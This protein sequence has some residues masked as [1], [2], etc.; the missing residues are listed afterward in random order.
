MKEFDKQQ[1]A[2]PVAEAATL[3]KI[4][5][6]ASLWGTA[7]GDGGGVDCSSN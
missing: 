6:T 2:P 1:D 7:F 5:S 3:G 4:V